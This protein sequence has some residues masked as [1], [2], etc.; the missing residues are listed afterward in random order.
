MNLILL[1]TVQLSDLSEIQTELWSIFQKC[2][3]SFRDHEKI[4]SKKVYVIEIEFERESERVN[5]EKVEW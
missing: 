3:M 5:H 4:E 2:I 1:K